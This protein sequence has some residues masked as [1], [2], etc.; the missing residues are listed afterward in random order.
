MIPPRLALRVLRELGFAD[1]A[2]RLPR[3]DRYLTGILIRPAGTD[4][5]A[6][7]HPEQRAQPGDDVLLY[8]IDKTDADQIGALNKE[9]DR[10]YYPR[11][12]GLS[13]DEVELVATRVP[14]QGARV[15]EVCCGAGRITSHLVRDGNRVVGLD[16]NRHCLAVARA[17]DGARVDYVLGDATRLPFADGGFDLTC[18]LENGFGVLFGYAPPTLAQMIRVTR[19]GGRVI[20]GLR[21][22][23][24]RPDNLHFYLTRNGLL[25]IA[26]TFDASSVGALLAT[27]PAAL[28]GRIVGRAD[29]PGA[30]RPWGGQTFYVELSLG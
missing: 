29:L 13:P 21:E 16:F 27:L 8:A 19:P 6:W 2:A 23:E 3:D 7:L 28:A 24:G 18:C 22:Q 26:Q 12:S 20:V 1:L 30:P 10:H 9:F 14:A 4:G 5:F 25:S 15:L 11:Q 17:R